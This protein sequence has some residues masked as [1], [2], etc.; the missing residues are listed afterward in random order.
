ML[1]TIITITHNKLIINPH[2]TVLILSNLTI[3]TNSTMIVRHTLPTI[4]TGLTQPIQLNTDKYSTTIK[5][6]KTTLMILIQHTHLRIQK[7][8]T[9][10]LILILGTTISIKTETEKGIEIWVKNQISTQTTILIGIIIIMNMERICNKI[11]SRIII[12]IIIII[13]VI[14]IIIHMTETMDTIQIKVLMMIIMIHIS[15]M[16]QIQIR[17]ILIAQNYPH[18]LENQLTKKLK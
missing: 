12:M 1:R 18:P 16:S 15:I 6:K 3:T 7:C 2:H 10:N 9:C 11:S 13:K 17:I 14:N 8:I 4:R 5:T